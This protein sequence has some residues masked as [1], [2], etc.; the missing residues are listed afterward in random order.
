MTN[1][2]PDRADEIQQARNALEK[3]RAVLYSA[4]VHVDAADD[5]LSE[6]QEAHTPAQVA[7]I[8]PI[9]KGADTRAPAAQDKA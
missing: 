1:E 8:G 6:L 4:Q 5:L 9:F 3:A 7:K 2:S